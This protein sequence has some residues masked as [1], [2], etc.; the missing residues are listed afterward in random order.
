MVAMAIL[1]T[2]LSLVISRGIVLQISLLDY[3]TWMFVCTR[4][5]M[6]K[7]ICRPSISRPTM[8]LL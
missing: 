2:V 3:A 4:K 7:L 8:F 1:V 6:N 5:F